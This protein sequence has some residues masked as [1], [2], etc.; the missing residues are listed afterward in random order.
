M[1]HIA[2]HLIVFILLSSFFIGIQI[3][4]LE[5]QSQAM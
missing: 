5:A 4:E 2:R 3:S 1:K